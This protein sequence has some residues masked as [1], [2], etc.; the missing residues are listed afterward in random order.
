MDTV[1]DESA[2]TEESD[3]SGED[4]GDL[5]SIEAEG[6]ELAFEAPVGKTAN[7]RLKGDIHAIPE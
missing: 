5:P 2:I 7:S 3:T 6:Q 1:A 4:A